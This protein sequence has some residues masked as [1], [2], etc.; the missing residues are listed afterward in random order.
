M[1]I[2]GLFLRLF[3]VEN[4]NK[5]SQFLDDLF[6]FLFFDHLDFFNIYFARSP[7]RTPRDSG[8]MTP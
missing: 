2:A 4:K 6:L 5:N 8:T 7:K 1:K 3:L